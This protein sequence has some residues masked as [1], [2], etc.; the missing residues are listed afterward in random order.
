MNTIISKFNL[1]EYFRILL[2]GSYLTIHLYFLLQ[3]FS[4]IYLVTLPW[5]LIVLFGLFFSIV[6][7]SLLYSLDI[8]RLF[9][10]SIGYIP[11]NLMR[12]EFPNRYK[13]FSERELEHEY[14][15]WYEKSTNK[16]KAKTELLSGLYHL[17]INLSATAIIVCI[18]FCVIPNIGCWFIKVLNIIILISSSLSAFLI[19]NCRLRYQWQRN[20]WEFRY[21]FIQQKQEN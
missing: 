20:Y 14:Y 21:E 16:S 7:G 17:T 11:T 1:Y 13:N 12:K 6:F 19:V 9:K 5:W 18:A 8:P 10:Y 4:S 2:P 3:Y 15:Q